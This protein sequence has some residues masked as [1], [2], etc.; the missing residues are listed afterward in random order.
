MSSPADASSAALPG[1]YGRL[2]ARVREAVEVVARTDPNPVD[3]F[4]GLYITD[5]QAR[6]WAGREPLP[7][8]DDERI[9]AAARALGLDDL[10]TD[11]LALCAA[12]EL[13][14]RLGRLIAY[15]HD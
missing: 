6:S 1:V 10:D 11:V 7:G 5:E 2:Q 9:E 14:P 4:R 13:S 3:P 8:E 12:P 15:L